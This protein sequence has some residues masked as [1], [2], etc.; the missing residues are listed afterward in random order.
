MRTVQT[1]AFS[2]LSLVLAAT[3]AGADP[4]SSKAPIASEVVTPSAKGPKPYF[5]GLSGECSG[6]SCIHDFGKK[7]KVRT[8]DI[9]TCGMSS[10]GGEG[11]YAFIY[12]DTEPRYIV[13]VNSH[14]VGGM[15]DFSMSVFQYPFTVPDGVRLT[16][17]YF[18]GGTAGSSFCSIEGTLG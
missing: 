13:P 17:Y 6:S 9:V 14:S 1:V 18:T 10:S 11:I 5:A 3:T 4:L 16:V 7:A 8:I 2:M 15:D 12:F